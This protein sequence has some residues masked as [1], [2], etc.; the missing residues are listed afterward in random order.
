M[1]VQEKPWQQKRLCKSASKIH[2]LISINSQATSKKNGP[3]W[4]E[5]E[6]TCK[7]SWSIW[8]NPNIWKNQT[9]DYLICGACITLNP[10]GQKLDHYTV[11]QIK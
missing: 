10:A 2:I 1:T 4:C 11:T 5:L 9:T 8:T 7:E 6:N 3:S